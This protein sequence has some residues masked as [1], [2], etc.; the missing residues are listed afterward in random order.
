MPSSAPG[1]SSSVLK[2]K[3]L[4]LASSLIIPLNK[5]KSQYKENQQ[6]FAVC[7]EQTARMTATGNMLAGKGMHVYCC[8]WVKSQ[9]IRRILDRYLSATC[10]SSAGLDDLG[11]QQPIEFSMLIPV[12]A[13][14]FT[15]DPN[16]THIPHRS[17]NA[18]K[19]ALT[20]QPA[21]T[22]LAKFTYM[23]AKDKSK[24]A[25]HGCCKDAELLCA[26]ED[27]SHAWHCR[28]HVDQCRE[29]N[30]DYQEH[31]ELCSYDT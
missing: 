9:G 28:A 12:L 29:Q 2:Y 16:M 1:H 30:L 8:Q 15:Q 23:L 20:G 5:S 22:T 10:V 26:L 4:D 3:A 25:E 18:T 11:A 13:L 6:L 31:R 19:S 17:S 14:Y 24:L 27:Q 21:R 7:I